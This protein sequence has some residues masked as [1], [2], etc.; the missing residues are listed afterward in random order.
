VPKFDGRVCL[1]AMLVLAWT[2]SA[3][4]ARAQQPAMASFKVKQVIGLEAIKHNTTGQVT[5][6]KEALTFSV[7]PTKSDLPI[8]EIQDV[9]TGADS[10]RMIGGTLGTIS[11]LGPYG[12]GRFLSLFRE[13]ID[14]L[15][16]EYRDANGGLHGAIFTLPQGQGA[17]LKAQLVAAGAKASPVPPADPALATRGKTAGGQKP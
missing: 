12:S 5:V 16:I 3:G 8:A 13:K 11:M 6:S 17:T 10:Q 4:L 1:S 15:T 14:T 7:G 2:A 9:L